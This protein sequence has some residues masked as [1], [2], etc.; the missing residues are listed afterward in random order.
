MLRSF[1]V[2]AFTENNGLYGC[3]ATSR[4][5]SATLSETPLLAWSELCLREM[6][7]RSIGPGFQIL[8]FWNKFC[9]FLVVPLKVI[10]ALHLPFPPQ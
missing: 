10:L 9:L 5:L 4:E 7:N 3:S 2:L 1:R 8:V 6:L